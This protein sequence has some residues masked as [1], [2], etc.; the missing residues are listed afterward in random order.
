MSST[1]SVDTGPGRFLIVGLTSAGRAF[2]PSDWAERLAGIM[3][4]FQPAGMPRHS[5]LS[6]SPYVL[7][8]MHEGIRCLVVDP[9]LREVEPLAYAFLLNFA[10]DND[11]QL[12]PLGIEEQP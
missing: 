12:R 2:R 10:R 4:R 6:Y 3:S 1:A 5:H 8:A 7:P 11:L 9:R